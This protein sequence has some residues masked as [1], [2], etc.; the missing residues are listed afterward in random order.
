MISDELLNNIPKTRPAKPTVKVP[1]TII[2]PTTPPTQINIEKEYDMASFADSMAKYSSMFTDGAMSNSVDMGADSSCAPK[3]ENKEKIEMSND[4]KSNEDG[5][6]KGLFKIFLAALK[7]PSKFQY[8]FKGIES[9]GKSLAFG[10]EGAVKSTFLGI[11][12]VILVVIFLFTF[13][14][15]YFSCLVRFFVTLPGCFVSHII[16]CI[17]SI[18]Y[19]IF[20][21]TSFIFWM[22]TG[23]ELMPYYE[24]VFEQIDEF[25]DIFAQIAGFHFWKFPQSVIKK[26]YTCNNK[27][28]RLKD[29]L[30]DVMKITKISDK[31]KIDFGKKVP[32]FMKPA[33]P[34]IYKTAYFV[35]KLFA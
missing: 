1:D 5:L 3:P 26:C 33:M 23:I 28:L 14:M 10:I 17:S 22:G 32:R 25:D 8:I 21:L 30:A 18:L 4:E 27:V 13:T 12:D 16:T 34:H 7:L 24:V 19:L 35:N 29:I 6:L 15:K 2:P 31:I 20:P 11:E 9:G